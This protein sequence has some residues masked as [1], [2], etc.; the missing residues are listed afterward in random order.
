MKDLTIVNLGTT[1]DLEIV[2]GDLTS[3]E[4]NA[5]TVQHVTYRLHTWLSES[6]YDRTRGVPYKE[7]VFDVQPM[8][9][10]ALMIQQYVLDS[11]GVISVEPIESIELDLTTLRMAPVIVLE[12]RTV[13]PVPVE[14]SP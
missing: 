4:Q 5:E 8:E 1:F 9:G 6:P 13:V 3:V 10:I 14:I 11:D 7:G 12:D 2:D